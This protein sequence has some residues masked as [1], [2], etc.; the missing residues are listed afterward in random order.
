MVWLFYDLIFIVCRPFLDDIV[1]K[2]LDLDYDGEEILKLLGVRKFIA[3]Y[4]KNLDDVLY[5]YKLTGGV[6][7]AYKLE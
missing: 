4:I 5:N 2:G 6:I 1:V 7:N 3:K